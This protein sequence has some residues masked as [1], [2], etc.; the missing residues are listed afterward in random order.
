MNSNDGALT[1]IQSER[2]RRRIWTVPLWPA[3]DREAWGLSRSG[4]G[5][6]GYDNPAFQWRP[7]TAEKNEDAYGRYLAWL[8]RR[9]LFV[10]DETPAQRITPD[11]VTEYVADMRPALSPV[12]VAIFIG[13]L[14]SA[15]KTLAPEGGWSWLSR[16]AT[17]L[18]LR[19]KP[20]REKRQT[21]QH[22]RDLYRLGKHL[23]DTACQASSGRRA[24]GVG[25][26]KRFQA[27]LVIALLAARP[28]RIRN[29][30]A[31]TVGGSLKWGGNAYRLTFTADETKTGQ[32]IDEPFPSDLVAYL[33]EFVKKWRLLLLKQGAK[34]RGIAAHKRLWVNVR[35]EPMTEPSLRTLVEFHTKKHFGTSLWPHLFRDCLL[36]SVAIDNPDQMRTSAVLL[37]HASN[38]TGEKHYNQARMLDASRRYGAAISELRESLMAGIRAPRVGS[39]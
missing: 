29:F 16:K 4:K 26:A 11:R 9:G 35:G 32:P 7:R 24:T 15:A 3:A 19:A 2:A 31:I 22:S 36:T 39:E 10:E 13:G 8:D 17:R 14:T 1:F 30:Q 23:M 20:S 37:G 25:A 18:K 33:E 34:Y 38:Q 27:G 12:S 28:L 21:V 5:P 6:D